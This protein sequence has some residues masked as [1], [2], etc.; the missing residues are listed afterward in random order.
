MRALFSL[1][2]RFPPGSVRVIQ[3]HR[4]DSLCGLSSEILLIYNTLMIDNKRHN[5]RNTVLC[6]VCNHAKPSDHLPVNNVVIGAACGILA[7]GIEDPEKIP[8]VRYRLVLR[9][10]VPFKGGL[11]SKIAEWTFLFTPFCLPVK[12][13]LLARC[14][15]DL[16]CI[17]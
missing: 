13:I 1:C 11:G 10:L 8:M 6:R 9:S 7:L 14:T 3:L 16:L 2:F 15:Y 4:L 17:F 12:T 5:A